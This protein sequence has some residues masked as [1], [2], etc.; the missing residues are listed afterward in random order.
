MGQHRLA[1]DVADRENMRNVR[2]HLLVDGDEA[3]LVDGDARRFGADA[4]A[5]GPAA[6]GHQHRVENVLPGAVGAFEG[7]VE[8]VLLGLDARD[9]G[10]QA[11][12][13]VALLDSL[14]ERRDDVAIH[15]RN[16]LVHHLDDA[17][18]RTQRVVD[19]RHLEADDPAAQDEQPL[20]D[21]EQLECAGRIPDAG[22]LGDETW[23]DR[24]RAGRDDRVGEADDLRP[25]GGFDG[26]GL[27]RGEL[28]FAP[29][30]DDLALAGEAREPRR[31]PLDDALLPTA[32]PPEIDAGSAELYAMR[33]EVSGFIYHFSYVQ[34]RLRGY[35]ADVETNA[36][37][38]LVPLDEHDLL[39]EVGG[40]KGGGIAAWARAEHEYVAFEIGFGGRLRR[41]RRSLRGWRSRRCGRR[42]RF[43]GRGRGRGLARPGRQQRPLAHLVADLDLD[44]A[45]HARLWR[46]DI[47]G[48]LVALQGQEHFLLGDRLARLDVDFDDRHVL[49]VA[50]IG[51]PDLACHQGSLRVVQNDVISRN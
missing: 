25:L 34:Q 2:S 49:E 16:Q 18:L 7:D 26:E 5:V 17:D 21:V 38:R 30:D 35:A 24:L 1:H 43:R 31:Q 28:A 45:D 41:W 6:D 9:L 23:R 11:N 32:H 27:R 19:R 37:E 44:L 15:A 29:D 50:D 22:V 13:L 8:T 51:K 20:G 12:F 46:G 36:A 14:G 42:G 47:Q 33:A 4:A 10:F 40:A 3:A 39:P 48:G